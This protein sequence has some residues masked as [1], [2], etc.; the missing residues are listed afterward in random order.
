MP[1]KM[2]D[3]SCSGHHIRRME[4]TD[5]NIAIQTT[6]EAARV[7]SADGS[8]NARLSFLAAVDK[9]LQPFD[10][11]FYEIRAIQERR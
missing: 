5:R 1:E 2:L 6:T 10:A 8:G 9:S 11:E 3:D 7:S 4:I